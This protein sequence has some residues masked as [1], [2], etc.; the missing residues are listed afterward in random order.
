ML[1]QERQIDIAMTLLDTLGTFR[2]LEK[3]KRTSLKT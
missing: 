1:K 3:G 2:N